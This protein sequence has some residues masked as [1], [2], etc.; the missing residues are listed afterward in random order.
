MVSDGRIAEFVLGTQSLTMT[1]ERAIIKLGLKT[2]AGKSAWKVGPNIN[3]VR[4]STLR[5]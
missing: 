4:F 1:D 2:G 3:S 5:L